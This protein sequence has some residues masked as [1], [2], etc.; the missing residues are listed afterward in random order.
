V[1][2]HV[3]TLGG[4]ILYQ[5]E[6]WK[7]IYRQDGRTGFRWPQNPAIHKLNFALGMMH[8]RGHGVPSG[9]DDSCT[10][11]SG[12]RSKTATQTRSTIWRF[13]FSG[14]RKVVD[15]NVGVPQP[16]CAVQLLLDMHRHNY[17]PGRGNFEM[18]A[19]GLHVMKMSRLN[20]IRKAAEQGPC[21]CPD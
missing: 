4:Q 9:Q 12:G 8:L 19:Q 1:N 17:A 15:R 20:V 2:R 11:V 7:R 3:Q 5:G 6:G 13:S 16:I 10:N 18:K 14:R 21:R